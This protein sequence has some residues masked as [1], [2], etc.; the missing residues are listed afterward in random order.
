MSTTDARWLR[1][2]GKT[3]R[4]TDEWKRMQSGVGTI[5]GEST[6]CYCPTC[7]LAFVDDN[8][9]EPKVHTWLTGHA[10]VREYNK[11]TIYTKKGLEDQ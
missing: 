2:H 6:Y 10:T 8:L 11:Q 4:T 1:K 3:G 7:G 5:T 9:H